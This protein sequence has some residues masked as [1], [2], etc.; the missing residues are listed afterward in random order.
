M[1]TT[2]ITSEDFCR[3]CRGRGYLSFVEYG[4]G[5]EQRTIH[6]TC[7]HCRGSGK[8]TVLVLP[9]RDKGAVDTAR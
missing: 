4:H 7:S 9:K 5:Y 6:E 1:T 2:A 8:Q 3:G